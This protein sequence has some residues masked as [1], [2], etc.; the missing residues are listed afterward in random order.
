MTYC[1]FFLAIELFFLSS[2][3]VEKR[4]LGPYITLGLIHANN[5]VGFSLD[6]LTV[7]FRGP[8]YSGS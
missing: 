4:T 6:V 5:L 7:N 2:L 3:L 8:I 1:L